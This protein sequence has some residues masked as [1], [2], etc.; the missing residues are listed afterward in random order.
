MTTWFIV[1]LIIFGLLK[2]IVT[3]IPTSVVD[4]LISRFELHPK[5]GDEEVTITIE[6]R[7]LQ[8]E[9]KTQIINY[10]N[11]AIFVEQYYAPPINNGTPIVIGT[12]RGKTDIRFFIYI[13]DE[14]V[15][16]V[17]KYKKK[18][19]AY[20]LLSRELIKYIQEKE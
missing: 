16:V 19:I 3:S 15:D 14:H 8:G 10:F 5:L 11:D 2:I 4:S 7:I 20:K 17:K 18:V 6:D 9:E 12:K 1:A 13:H